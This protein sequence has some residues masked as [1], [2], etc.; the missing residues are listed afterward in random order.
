M[1]DRGNRLS[2]NLLAMTHLPN[3]VGRVLLGVGPFLDDPVEELAASDPG[4]G[5]EKVRHEIL[6]REH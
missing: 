4:E 2:F 1:L 3:E 6:E 5:N